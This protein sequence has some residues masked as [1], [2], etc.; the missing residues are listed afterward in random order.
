MIVGGTVLFIVLGLSALGV[1]MAT[2]KAKK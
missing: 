2:L 1:T